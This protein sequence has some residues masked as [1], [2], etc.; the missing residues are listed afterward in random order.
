[1]EYTVRSVHSSSHRPSMPEVFI[2]ERDLRVDVVQVPLEG[3][4]VELLSQC[5]TF[6]D[7]TIVSPADVRTFGI[8]MLFVFI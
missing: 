1:M 2:G 3:L 5:K 4:A 7:V 8:E 6:S